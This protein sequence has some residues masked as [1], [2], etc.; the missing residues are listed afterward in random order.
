[1]LVPNHIFIV[2]QLPCI[3]Q[4]SGLRRG[5]YQRL[6][7]A[8]CTVAQH[9]RKRL[10]VLQRRL[11]DGPSCCHFLES[12]IFHQSALPSWMFGHLSDTFHCTCQRTSS[13]SIAC[14]INCM[15]MWPISRSERCWSNWMRILIDQHIINSIIIRRLRVQAPLGLLPGVLECSV[16]RTALVPIGMGSPV[17]ERRCRHFWCS[18]RE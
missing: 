10:L 5:T 13:N 9:R 3:L 15:C 8:R 18:S 14:K 2:N 16:E 1:M 6:T 12:K 17:A 4:P 7:L 11:P